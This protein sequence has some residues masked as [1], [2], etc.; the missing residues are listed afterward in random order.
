[1]W[2]EAMKKGGVVVAALVA[3]AAASP[4]FAADLLPVKAPVVVEVPS[5]TQWY[6]GGEVGG[7]WGREDWG[8]DCIQGAASPSPFACGGALHNLPIVGFAGAPDSSAAFRTSGVRAGVYL[9]ATYQV[10]PNWVMGFE[11]DYAWSDQSSSVTGIVGCSTRGCRGIPLAIP[12]SAAPDSTGIALKDD[13]SVRLRGGYLVTPD[14]LV[15]GTGGVA[16][17]RVEGSMNCVGNRN[18]VSPACFISTPPGGPSQTDASWRPGWTVGAGLEW[19]FAHN[20][21]LR[22]EYRYADFGTWK[23]EFFGG[24]G[25]IEVFPNIKLTTQTATAGIA[26]AFPISK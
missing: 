16:F 26:Y 2:G 8:T 15:Y 24:S 3:V 9:G 11:G 17:Q 6:I 10:A 23:P 13:F 14:I 12:V 4:A 7:K 1:M 21:L 5:W 25:V 18:P 22:G 20:W 19:K